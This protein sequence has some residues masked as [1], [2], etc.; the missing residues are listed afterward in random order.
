MIY[1]QGFTRTVVMAA[2]IWT[3]A[4]VS[5]GAPSPSRYYQV[6]NIPAPEGV[7]PACGGLSFLPDGRL[8]AVFD[9]GEVCILDPR[10]KKWSKF[11]EGLHTPL[12]VLAISD[13]E[14]LVC[15]RPE[16][17][18]L[19]DTKGAGVAD[20][21]ECVSDQWGLSG[22]YHEFAYGPVKDA[23][24]NLY[25]ALGS[26][27]RGGVARYEYRG[28]FDAD[29]GDFGR[30]AMFSVVPYRGW[31]VRISPDG[32]LV[33]IGCGFRQPNG[34]VLDPM[35]RI[36]VTDNQG[37]WVG[38]SKLHFVE[39][40][41]FYGHP[42]S[43][44]WRS[45]WKGPPSV[46]E[47][48]RMR[49][50]GTVLFPHAILANSPGQPVFDST[51]GK[52][53]PYSGQMFVTEFNIPRLLRVMFEEVSGELQGAVTP[54]FDGAPLRAGNIRLAFAPDGS[55]WVGQSQRR[56][57]WPADEGI[58]RLSWKGETPMDI[59]AM[60]LTSTGF[61]F[62]FTKPVDLSSVMKAG[63]FA[64]RRYYYLYQADYG[65]P[66]MDIHQVRASHLERVQDGRG[67]RFDVD[68]LKAGYIYEFTL[69]GVRATDGS[70][71]VNPLIAYTANRLRDG[72]SRPI[73]WPQPTGEK[74]GSG[75]DL[76]T[77]QKHE[78]P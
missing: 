48:D 33:P 65:S 75:E 49:H 12:G 47:L 73:P 68:E 1:C 67:I 36:L 66:R 19:V 42:S 61:E 64:G 39:P 40:G 74:A 76:P 53:G 38:T 77:V 17:T 20:L 24:G 35:G 41:G 60:H 25:V 11:A 6:E 16:L 23:Q 52:F 18:R 44:V 43:L 13:R 69:N 55:L 56:L 72:S 34:I 71:L 37:D 26:A 5:K 3:S 63:A 51:D 15:Q 78:G 46:L 14:I 27:S 10:T 2:I 4:F 57:G 8:V 32:S 50:E 7:A 9:H 45:D 29:G 59:L 21:Y 31:V 54:F 28:R 30:H 70:A 22:N 58:Q 62:T